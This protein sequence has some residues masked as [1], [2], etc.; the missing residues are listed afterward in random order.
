MKT[1]F[2]T[3][4]ALCLAASLGAQAPSTQYTPEQLDQLVGPIAL[5]PDP[6]VA[7]ILP[8]ST[9]PSDISLAAQYLATGGD[10]AGIDSQTWDPSV[11]GLAHYPGVLKWMNDNLDWT[12]TLGAAFA[13]QPA[14]VMKS[15]QQQRAK[16]RAAGTLVDTPQQQVVMEGDDIRIVPTDPNMIYVPEYDA[17][18][19]YDAP[20]GD[21]GPFLTF[22]VGY[23][24]GPWLGFE[25]DWD[26]FGIWM[27]PWQRG[28]AYRREW[29][30]AGGGGRR[31]HPDA[32]RGRE[33]V[34]NYYRPT[35]TAAGPIPIAG[36][37][38]EP[39]RRVAAPRGAAPVSRPAQVERSTPDYRG[40]S[41]PSPR[42]PAPQGS[43][44]GGYSRGTQ[45]RDYS[46]RGQTSRKA[47]VA[48]ARAAAPAR[49][50]PSSRSSTPAP[51]G[52][53]R[54]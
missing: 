45:T 30:G 29:A 52:R 11:K 41:T 32:V 10:P 40:Y 38:P 48:P 8:A 21:E 28:W 9:F 50:E 31:W 36:A 47:P 23:P 46:T 27:G 5:Y 35:V 20:A 34:R 42:T 44:F 26:D 19:V 18:D 22:G 1:S 3:L 14:D 54:R 43:L 16:A 37:R 7:L 4:L 2:C 53:D 49:A 13:M 12:Q 24:V 25:C 15:V 51:A 17:D 39:T 33:L 6:L